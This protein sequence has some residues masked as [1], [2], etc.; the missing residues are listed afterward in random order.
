MKLGKL[1]GDG[2]RPDNR[3]LQ[4]NKKQQQ[5]AGRTIISKIQTNR[6]QLQPTSNEVRRMDAQIGS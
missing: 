3:P 4:N 2:R 6:T 1:E 5:H